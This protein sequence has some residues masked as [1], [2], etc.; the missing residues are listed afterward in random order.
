MI[1][2]VKILLASSSPRRRE[3]LSM[4][5]VNFRVVK[6]DAEEVF[7]SSPVETVIENAKRKVKFKRLSL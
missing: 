2:K 1:N 3:I 4:L 5:R 6:A 7:L